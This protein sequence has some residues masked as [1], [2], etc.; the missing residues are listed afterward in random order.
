MMDAQKERHAQF[1]AFQNEKAELN[2]LH[3]LKM[4]EIFMKYSNPPPQGAQ[5]HLQQQTMPAQY[6]NP[7]PYS[8]TP[9]TNQVASG[10]QDSHVLDMD[11]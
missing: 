7:I 1:L 10:S 2:R 5:P 9:Q 8:H 11:S 4:L 6:Y 3:E